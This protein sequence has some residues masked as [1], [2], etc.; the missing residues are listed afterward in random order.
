MCG[1]EPSLDL[2]QADLQSLD[3]CF[4]RL[5][6]WAL[7]PPAL[8]SGLGGEKLPLDEKVLRLRFSIF[9]FLRGEVGRV[10]V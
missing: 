3:S 9:H 6:C 2:I 10:Q 4:Q 8:Q 7:H 1:L 5:L